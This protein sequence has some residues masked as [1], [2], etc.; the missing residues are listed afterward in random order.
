MPH[1]DE[2]AVEV[3]GLVHGYASTRALNDIDLKVRPGSFVGLIGPDG[4]G[5]ST[6]L[7]VIA[8]AKQIQSGR[9]SVL[10]GDMA[11]RRSRRRSR[12]KVHSPDR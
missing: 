5:K 3:E 4:V 11:S 12:G 10:G 8:G 9:V 7:G 1:S 6:L 2:F